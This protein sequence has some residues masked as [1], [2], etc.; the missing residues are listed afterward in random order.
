MGAPKG[1]SLSSGWAT[2]QRAGAGCS[3]I[4]VQLAIHESV[5]KTSKD[6]GTQKKNLKTGS[7]PISHLPGR[8]W[9]DRPKTAV[10]NLKLSVPSP[11]SVAKLP[12]GPDIHITH[13]QRGAA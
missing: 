12:T 9:D 5:V 13:A 7:L 6:F 1:S 8:L 2:C 11:L 4:P 3:L 10:E